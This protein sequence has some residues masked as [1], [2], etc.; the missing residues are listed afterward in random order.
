MESWNGTSMMAEQTRRDARVHI[1][2]DA[3]GSYGC[4]A[5]DPAS[6][7]WIQ[8]QWNA[9][10]RQDEMAEQSITAKEL[11][12]IVLACAVWGRRWVGQV[13]RVSCDNTG[14]VAVV[15]SGYSRS[16]QIMHLLRCLF[17]I[18]AHFQLEMWACHI[19]G[20][21]N[22]IAD[23][24]SRN[25]MSVF[26]SRPEAAGPPSRKHSPGAAPRLDIQGLCKVVQ[27]LFSAGLAPA[28]QRN[29][30]SGTNWFLEFCQTMHIHNPFP[31]TEQVL[32]LFS[33]WRGSTPDS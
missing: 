28:S 4:G 23:A 29:Y 16:P 5:W 19:P 14:T 12:P 20:V 32:S 7:E 6:G 10:N 26:F 30:R 24:I 25:N 21:Q 3:S 27:Q 11:L 31:L 8:L 18:R 22:I 1:W 2:T 33:L 13:V 9:V 17:F 15:N